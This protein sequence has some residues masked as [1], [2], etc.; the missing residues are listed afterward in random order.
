[1]KNPHEGAAAAADALVE[2][3]LDHFCAPLVGVVPFRERL[4]LRHEIGAHVD[5]LIAEYTFQGKAP[6]EATASAL[7]EMGEPWAS[8]QAWLAQWSVGRQASPAS[9][10]LARAALARPFAFFGLATMLNL[11]VLEAYAL[12]PG[13]GALLP[14]VVLFAALFPVVAGVC[15]GWT[16]PGNP[17]RGTLGALLLLI[18][19]SLATGALL[20]P[21]TDGLR[22]AAVQLVWW[23]PVGLASAHLS[24]ALARSHRRHRFLRAVRE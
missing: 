18:L 14:L 12:T 17:A 8:G 13:G 23:L 4:A 9:S 3:F 19:D 16:L 22:F 20:L 1:M 7:R 11:L 21:Q 10:R 5:A 24:A 6:I 15:T 2:D